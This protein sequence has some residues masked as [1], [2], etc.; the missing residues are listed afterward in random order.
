M[1]ADA[2]KQIRVRFPNITEDQLWRHWNRVC[3]GYEALTTSVNVIVPEW[4]KLVDPKKIDIGGLHGDPYWLA[5]R[6][7]DF[8]TV[9]AES[10]RIELAVVWGLY[11][12]DLDNESEKF[13][14]TI[15]WRTL[16]TGLREISSVL[17]YPIP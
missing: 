2:T 10:L 7:A 4:W 15:M 9:P 13:C 3:F 1:L 6:A 8:T 16:V 11:P 12:C 17:K 5:L 14:L